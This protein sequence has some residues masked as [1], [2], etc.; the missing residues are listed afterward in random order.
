MCGEMFLRHAVEMWQL[1]CR[2]DPARDGAW[3]AA[4]RDTPSGL[5]AGTE[6]GI[7][8]QIIK[9]KNLSP[10]SSARAMEVS[11]ARARVVLRGSDAHPRLVGRREG[12][13]GVVLSRR[14]SPW[15]AAKE[16]A[17]SSAMR[18]GSEFSD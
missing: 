13:C 7:T 9:L 18:I 17:A 6:T 12:F 1:R 3:S 8:P 4:T 15:R 10:S 16:G 14:R 11:G 2:M 5:G